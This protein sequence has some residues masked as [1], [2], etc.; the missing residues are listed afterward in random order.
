MYIV[1]IVGSK[2]ETKFKVFTSGNDALIYSRGGALKEFDGAILLI[3][4]YE[5]PTG[6]NV[7]E[8]VEMVK[9]GNASL[10]KHA[11]EPVTEAEGEAISRAEE[12]RSWARMGFVFHPRRYWNGDWG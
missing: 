1:K 8:A 3:E 9:T 5:T 10:L 2:E 7:Y 11:E 6:S 4:T 12:R